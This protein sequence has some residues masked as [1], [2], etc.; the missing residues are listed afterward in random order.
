MPTLQFKGRNIIWNHHLTVP[1]HTLDEVPALSFDPAKGEGNIIVEGDNLTALKALLPQYAGKINCIFIDPPYNTGNDVAEGIGWTYSDNVNSPVIQQ[2]LN[3]EVGVD[4][5]TKHDKWLC[6]ITP[7]LKLLR[8]LLDDKGAIF[9]AIDDNEYANLKNIMNDIFGEENFVANIVWQARK[10]VQNDTDISV[11]HNYV[12]VFAKNRRQKD[13]RLKEANA[14]KWYKDEGF[15]LRPLTLDKNK[16]SNP[17]NDPRGMWKADPFDA[18]NVRENLTYAIVNPNTGKEY[19]PPKGRHWRTEEIN[20]EKLLK[21][22]RILFGKTGRSGPQLKVFWDDKKEYGE[23]DTSWWGEG[24]FDSYIDE[25]IDFETISEWTNYGTTTSGS[26]LLQKIFDGEKVFNNPKPL[27]LLMHII[28]QAANKDALILDSFAGSGTTGQAVLE[29]NKE[30]G[31]NR[32]FILVQM[33]E[34]TEAEPDKNIARDITAERIKR[35]IDKYE[36]NSG[37][38]YYKLGTA[39]DAETLLQGDLPTYE[40][41]AKYVFYLCT[42]QHHSKPKEIKPKDYFVGNAGN[43]AIYL[44]YQQDFEKLTQLALNLSL[45]EKFRKASAN[46]PVVVYAP[47]CFLGEEYLQ[48]FNIQFV[49]IPYN[50]FQKNE[51][52]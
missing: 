4:D 39:I 51:Q 38:T 15:V 3:K 47:A 32:K 48:D 37:F 6:M 13:R 12:L 11:N 19:F 42:G 9:I 17:D 50:L 40:Q 29:L 25:D 31:G 24:S 20:Y 27:E 1:Y 5:L 2:W 10:S 21:E 52:P 30:D 45:A 18:P 22:D 44:I 28:R 36:L 7:R 43:T 34:A 41:F 23:V 26:Q 46:K 14:E 33:T 8:D 16:F 49:S 35:A